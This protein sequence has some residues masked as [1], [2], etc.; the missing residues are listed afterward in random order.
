MTPQRSGP[1]LHPHCNRGLRR[2]N[3]P[4]RTLPRRAA[5]PVDPFDF[6]LLP[7]KLRPWGAD[8]TER[9]QC[10]PDYVGASIVAALGTVIGTKLVIKPKIEDDWQVVANQWCLIIGRPGLMKRH[11]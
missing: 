3:G 9:M 2:R 5:Q 6:N 11:H 1:Q 4:I 10:P 7:E 8:A